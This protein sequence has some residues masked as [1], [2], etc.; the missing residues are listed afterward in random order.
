MTRRPS[1]AAVWTAA[2]LSTLPARAEAPMLAAQIDCGTLNGAG[3]V[4][5]LVAGQYAGTV[6]VSCRQA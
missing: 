1:M 4:H 6:V 3:K 5:I 2:L